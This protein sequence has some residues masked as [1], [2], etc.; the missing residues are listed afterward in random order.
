ML[1]HVAQMHGLWLEDLYKQVRTTRRSR[2]SGLVKEQRR[3]YSHV[4]VHWDLAAFKA[5]FL[6]FGGESRDSDKLL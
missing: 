6:G 2:L 5:A 4:G 1:R 3:V